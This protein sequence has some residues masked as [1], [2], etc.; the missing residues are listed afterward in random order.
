MVKIEIFEEKSA[1]LHATIHSLKKIRCEC[2]IYPTPFTK[3]NLKWIKDLNIKPETRQ[4]LEEKKEK[5]PFNNDFVSDFFFGYNTK[6][7][8]NKAK[9]TSGT[10]S[11]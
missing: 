4:A 9:K 7:S 10:T 11:N 6:S 8:G 1:T 3:I 5:K 2:A